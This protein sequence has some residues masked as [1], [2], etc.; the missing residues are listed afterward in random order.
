M[1]KIPKFNKGR[2]FSKTVGPGKKCKINKHRA[3]A[4]GKGAINRQFYSAF[5]KK[6]G[7]YL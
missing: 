7:K 1:A 5:K 2:A 4:F 6:F 3:S